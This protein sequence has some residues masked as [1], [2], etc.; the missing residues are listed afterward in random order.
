MLPWDSRDALLDHVAHLES[1]AGIRR[2]FMA[3]GA[4][5]PVELA[6]EDRG[7]LIGI[8]NEWSRTAG[9]YDELPEGLWDLRCVLIDDAHDDE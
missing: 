4:S 9:G 8:L 1:A 5:R 6:T 7:Q 2:A 3:V